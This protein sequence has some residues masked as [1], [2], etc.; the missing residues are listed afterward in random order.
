[1]KHFLKFQF[2]LVIGVMLGSVVS[3]TVCSVAFN[4]MGYDTSNLTLIQECLEKQ[5]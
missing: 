1:M 4:M 2:G 5:V 3:A